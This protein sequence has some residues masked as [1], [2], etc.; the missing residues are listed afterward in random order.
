MTSL[1]SLMTSLNRRRPANMKCGTIAFEVA[2][3]RSRQQQQRRE[4][5]VRR[6]N[7]ILSADGQRQCDVTADS[8]TSL[9]SG[10]RVWSACSDARSISEVMTP[11]TVHK[12]Y[13]V[14]SAGL[15]RQPAIRLLHHV[16]ETLPLGYI[17]PLALLSADRFLKL[18]HRQTAVNLQQ[19]G[20]KYST[21]LQMCHYTTL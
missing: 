17:L 5:V 2:S 7:K 16:R 12:M 14:R 8:V 9:C 11:D 13:G 4:I 10:Q 6:Q 21:T 19:S 18:F 15:A 20:N 1:T 3:Y